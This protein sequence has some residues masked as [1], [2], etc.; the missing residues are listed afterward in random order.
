MSFMNAKPKVCFIVRACV[1]AHLNP[2]YSHITG[3][4]LT[5]KQQTGFCANVL[6]VV[7]LFSA[8]SFSQVIYCD[9]SSISVQ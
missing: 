5:N 9:L 1:C 4:K 7:G 6:N 3:A 2:L 8:I